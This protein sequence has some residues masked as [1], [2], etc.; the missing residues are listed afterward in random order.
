MVPPRA[1]SGLI[2]A[3]FARTPWANTLQINNER[4]KIIRYGSKGVNVALQGAWSFRHAKQSS[5]H[6][7]WCPY[8]YCISPKGGWRNLTSWSTY[9]AGVSAWCV[10]RLTLMT[11]EDAVLLGRD[12]KRSH[13]VHWRIFGG[14]CSDHALRWNHRSALLW[15]YHYKLEGEDG[16]HVIT[17]F[18]WRL[19]KKPNSLTRTQSARKAFT[20]A[21]VWFKLVIHHIEVVITSRPERCHKS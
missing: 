13:S 21:F 10:V 14:C 16:F 20:G 8:G 9:G 6:K 5:E 3:L 17:D 2:H 1:R 15:Y 11:R 18:L 7:V 4:S 12:F 19:A